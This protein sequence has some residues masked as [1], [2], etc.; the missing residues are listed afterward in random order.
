M[1]VTQ[2][3]VFDGESGES[4][5]MGHTKREQKNNEAV[6]NRISKELNRFQKAAIVKV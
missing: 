6:K 4:V 1:S 2:Q 3:M 5:L